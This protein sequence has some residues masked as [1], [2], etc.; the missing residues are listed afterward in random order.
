MNCFAEEQLFLLKK[1][2]FTLENVRVLEQAN[3]HFG[4]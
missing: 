3:L 1:E 4:F 2:K